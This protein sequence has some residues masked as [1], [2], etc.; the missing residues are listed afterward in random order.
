MRV[1]K[2]PGKPSTW[3]ATVRQAKRE[4]NKAGRS[5]VQPDFT[6][7][8]KH[9]WRW[10][11][12]YLEDPET[13][14]FRCAYCEVSLTADRYHGDVEHYRPKAAATDRNWY[15]NKGKR[16][17][18]SKNRCKLGYYWL[19][20]EWSNLLLAC[21]KCNGKKSD[22]FPVVG[23]RTSR[24]LIEGC[25]KTETPLLLNPYKDKHP[26]K[27]LEFDK[28]GAVTAAGSGVDQERGR[29]TIEICDL[30]RD[31]LRKERMAL[32][33]SAIQSINTYLMALKAGIDADVL[34]EM[35]DSL[36]LQMDAKHPHSGMIRIIFYQITKR[37]WK[38]L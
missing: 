20:Y 34:K 12:K 22:F 14:M 16:V 35:R 8:T 36:R 29:E 7:E 17:R 26:E 5:G 15:M 21:F 2:R 38:S 25:E 13:N 6:D 23:G 28:L 11:K 31:I 4:V 18:G 32:A 19:A 1:L 24:T 30:D 3:G 33:E 10:F 27:H 9:H 37:H